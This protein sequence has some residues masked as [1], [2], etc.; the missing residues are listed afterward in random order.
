MPILIV[1]R[2]IAALC[3]GNEISQSGERLRRIMSGKIVCGVTLTQMTSPA[4]ITRLQSGTGE[5]H[6]H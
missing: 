5:I 1:D 6:D 4:F 3:L 2:R